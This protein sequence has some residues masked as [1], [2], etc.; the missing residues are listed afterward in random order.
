MM[1]KEGLNRIVNHGVLPAIENEIQ[2]CVCDEVQSVDNTV[3]AI[4]MIIDD[5]DKYF[6]TGRA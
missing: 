6:Q 1:E 4:R 3:A 2:K 5:Y